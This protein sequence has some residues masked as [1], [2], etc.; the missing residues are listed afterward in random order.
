MVTR[1]EHDKLNDEVRMLQNRG[2]NLDGRI[3]V[4]SAVVSVLVSLIVS[5]IV[6]AAL[7]SLGGVR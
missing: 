4:A 7:H 1:P 6:A 2:A 5:L 3:T